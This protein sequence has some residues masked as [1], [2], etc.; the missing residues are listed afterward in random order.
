MHSI[1]YNYEAIEVNVIEICVVKSLFL[2][3][4]WT[5]IES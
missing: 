3:F 5:P 2:I 4:W 1:G